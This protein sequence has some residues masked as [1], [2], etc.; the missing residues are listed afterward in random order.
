[1]QMSVPQLNQCHKR[2]L[3]QTVLRSRSPYHWRC[4]F[5]RTPIHQYLSPLCTYMYVHLILGRPLSQLD[6]WIDGKSANRT[7]VV[8]RFRFAGWRV[9][10]PISF[11]FDLVLWSFAVC[12]FN[13]L[14]PTP[15]NGYFGIEFAIQ[16]PIESFTKSCP[17]TTYS[18]LKFFVCLF[19]FRIEIISY[20]FVFKRIYYVLQ[21]FIYEK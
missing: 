11:L 8:A 13:S 9:F 20:S 18:R 1:M 2:Q 4:L 16:K 7:D 5:N 10:K 14:Q 6:R 3:F 12:K 19:F 15:L 21:T 17:T